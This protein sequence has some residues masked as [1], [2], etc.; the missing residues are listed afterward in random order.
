M[1][2]RLFLGAIGTTATGLLAGCGGIGGEEDPASSKR[3]TDNTSTA[4]PS[5]SENGQLSFGVDITEQYLA[6]DGSTDDGANLQTAIEKEEGQTLIL[7]EGSG[8]INLDT[9]VAPSTSG[10][11]TVIWCV[12][13][14]TIDISDN[15][16]SGA[17]NFASAANIELRGPVTLAGATGSGVAY[18]LVPGD[19]FHGRKLTFSKGRGGIDVQATNVDLV[20]VTVEEQHDA[21]RGEASALRITDTKDLFVHGLTIDDA[22]RGIEIEDDDSNSSPVDGVEILD[23]SVSHIDNSG[24]SNPSACFAV[25]AHNH[26]AG[27]QIKDVALRS[28]T[29][30]SS[31]QGVTIKQ[32]GPSLSNILIDGLEIIDSTD[33]TYAALVYGEVTLRNIIIDVSS[34][35]SFGIDIG[36]G[37]VM[38]NDVD[39]RG[40]TPDAPNNLIRLTNQLTGGHVSVKGV[41]AAGDRWR[42]LRATGPVQLDSLHISN[43]SIDGQWLEDGI[44]GTG[45]MLASNG[46]GATIV[47]TDLSVNDPEQDHSINIPSPNAPVTM[48]SGS[49]NGLINVISDSHFRAVE[50]MSDR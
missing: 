12:G 29:L 4:P 8:V 41:H 34:T 32:D 47:N 3:T 45:D 24:A 6:A 25:D 23:Y 20:D 36:G 15:T 31:A 14:P 7:R 16:A 27:S 49:A 9:Q 38:L 11:Q 40:S 18:G 42:F 21:E 19:G 17:L 46:A 43:V 44:A 50:G 5:E 30:K 1:Q 39:F 26:E 33:G 2:R 35:P 37:D 22:D 13:G 48:V 28:G 10:K